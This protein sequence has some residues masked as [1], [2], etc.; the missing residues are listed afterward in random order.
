MLIGNLEGVKSLKI[1]LCWEMVDGFNV[2]IKS[3]NDDILM[4]VNYVFI[5]VFN[6]IDGVYVVESLLIFGEVMMCFEFIFEGWVLGLN[7]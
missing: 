7:M 4:V 2:E 6:N 1:C 5:E 3:I